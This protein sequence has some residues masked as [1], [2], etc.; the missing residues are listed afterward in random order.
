MDIQA[1]NSSSNRNNINMADLS[2]ADDVSPATPAATHVNAFDRVMQTDATDKAKGTDSSSGSG[3]DQ[4]E[5]MLEQLMK[6]IQQM[7]ATLDGNSQSDKGS[8]GSGGS[9]GG[10]SVANDGGGVT[11]V[12]GGGS[13]GSAG[14]GS[15]LIPPPTE[16]IQQLNLGG[17]PVTV[18]GDGS[19]SAEEVGA[20]AQSIQQLYQNSPTFKDM[21]DNS[22]DPSFEVSVGKRDD[23]ISWGNTDGRVFMNINNTAPG[24]SDSFQSLLGHEFAHASIDLGHGS[25]VE[26]VQ[27][28]VAREA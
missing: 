1:I 16:H 10:G 5:K 27:N 23:N 24:N 2:K 21:I 18:G 20:T 9:V 8:G 14:N 6:L 4:L 7:L 11:P 22:S 28:A 25:Q 3:N 15:D 17:K 26:Q 13:G 12:E 19:S